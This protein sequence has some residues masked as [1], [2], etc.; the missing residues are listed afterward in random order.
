[1]VDGYHKWQ[2]LVMTMSGGWLP[3]VVD[4]GDDHEWHEWWT[5]VWLMTMAWASGGY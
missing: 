4:F 2:T 5:L 3:Q 1:V